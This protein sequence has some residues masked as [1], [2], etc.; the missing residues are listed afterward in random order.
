M[1]P[2][3]GEDFDVRGS[4]RSGLEVEFGVVGGSLS[5]VGYVAA[6]DDRVRFFRGDF[7]DQPFPNLRIGGLRF[8]GIGEAHVS[9][10]DNNGALGEGK[11]CS[12]QQRYGELKH[13]SDC[14][15]ESVAGGSCLYGEYV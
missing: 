13:Y 10:R 6:D 11:R 1:I 2:Q 3:G 4:P 12:E 9:I 14:S 7:I 15:Y 5:D 8:L